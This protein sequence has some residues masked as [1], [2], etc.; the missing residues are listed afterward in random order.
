MS[1]LCLPNE[2]IDHIM[3]YLDLSS[4][5]ALGSSCF[6]TQDIL[7]ARLGGFN[8][9]MKKTF[10]S[11]KTSRHD[12]GIINIEAMIEFLG[13][14]PDHQPLVRKVYKK[15][16]QDFSMKKPNNNLI[17][18]TSSIGKITR[19]VPVHLEG[20]FLL[21]KLA[22]RCHLVQPITERTLKLAQISGPNLVALASCLQDQEVDQLEVTSIRCYTEEEGWALVQLLSSCSSWSVR[23]LCLCDQVGRATWRRLAS[24]VEP[25]Q[26]RGRVS[27]VYT[28]REVMA[29]GRREEVRQVWQGTEWRWVVDGEAVY[30]GANK[31]GASKSI[32]ASKG[33]KRGWSV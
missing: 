33:L 1:L 9:L 19:E 24:L 18:V 6:R 10:G 11:R 17:S 32:T 26:T 23:G 25:N 2:L 31:G 27:C 21:S 28:T 5:L 22:R 29:R 7:L 30:R 4:T 20:L 3:S 8:N 14:V 13:N 15:I 12:E 16:L